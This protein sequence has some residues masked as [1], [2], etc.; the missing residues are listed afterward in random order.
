MNVTILSPYRKKGEAVTPDVET[1]ALNF[2]TEALAFHLAEDNLSVRVIT[3]RPDAATASRWY[4]GN[5]T[6][7][8]VPKSGGPF[9]FFKLA[10]TIPRADRVVHLEHELYAFGGIITAFT[11]PLAIWALRHRGHA[12]VTT[13]H[14]VIP[15]E[16]IDRTFVK[17]YGVQGSPMIVR[18]IW[19]FLIR[20]V[21][22]ASTIVHVH[23]DAFADSLREQ[24]GVRSPIAVVP[25][26]IDPRRQLIE[27][28][29]ARRDIGIDPSSDVVCFFGFLYK[30]KGIVELLK[31]SR[32]LVEENP[33]IVLLIAGD[34][35]RRAADAH[36]IESLI[37]ALR[38]CPQV[39]FTGF[40]SDERLPKV[41]AAADVMILPY[42]FSM[43]S[44]GPL[45]L[46][47]SHELPV[48]LSNRFTRY[49]PEAPDVF[50]PDSDG[51]RHAI[52]QYFRD[53]SVRK[54]LQTFTL[55]HAE[56]RRWPLIAK[57]MR[58]LYERIDP[59]KN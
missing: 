16:K 39:V 40:V 8:E 48:L 45:T 2:V 22:L 51:I 50:E 47:V 52:E 28:A 19:K 46:A 27:K 32:R 4:D 53:A 10:L 31:C 26:G 42:T 1:T 9:G 24:Y 7:D 55:R 58:A 38:D 49:F 15:L 29:D 35:P 3:Q 12:V 34:L 44:S 5:V 41:L 14:G 33:R 36:E 37:T 6:V 56:E 54:R 11:V 25:L 30:R 18:A 13:L 59:R 23:E 17:S 57:R 20:G 21:C 43:S